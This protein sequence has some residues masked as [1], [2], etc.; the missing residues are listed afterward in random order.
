MTKLD[1]FSDDYYFCFQHD[2]EGKGVC[3]ICEESQSKEFEMLKQA[4]PNIE[5]YFIGWLDE[6]EI[7]EIRNDPVGQLTLFELIYTNK[8]NEIKAN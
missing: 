3:P 5:E 1:L 4:I 6:K 8:W 7:E 2:I